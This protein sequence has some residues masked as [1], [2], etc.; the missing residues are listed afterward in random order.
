MKNEII[1]ATNTLRKSDEFNNNDINIV[2]RFYKEYSNGN[3]EPNYKMKDLNGNTSHAIRIGE[4]IAHYDGVVKVCDENSNDLVLEYNSSKRKVVSVG[5][6]YQPQATKLLD[7]IYLEESLILPDEWDRDEILARQLVQLA[8]VYNGTLPTLSKDTYLNQVKNVSFELSSKE[9]R[10]TYLNYLDNI[11]K[12]DNTSL[13]NKKWAMQIHNGISSAHNC[14]LAYKEALNEKLVDG[15]KTP[16]EY[17][18]MVIELLTEAQNNNM[19][20]DLVDLCKKNNIDISTG[21]VNERALFVAVSD[22]FQKIMLETQKTEQ[23]ND[24]LQI[25]KSKQLELE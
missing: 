11:I 1:D 21:M 5:A 8:N 20:I 22:E 4:F 9:K 17:T 14:E 7:A 24:F 19:K 13:L 16:F 6:N 25:N 12:D 15:S 18:S 23:S 2:I 3:L 10:D